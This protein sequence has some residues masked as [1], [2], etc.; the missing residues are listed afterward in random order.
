MEAGEPRLQAGRDEA[1]SAGEFE[2]LARLPLAEVLGRLGDVEPHAAWFSGSLTEGL[3]HA[4]SDVDIYVMVDEIPRGLVPTREDDGFC[5]KVDV[6]NSRRVDFEYWPTGRVTALADKLAGA[7]LSREDKN[8]LDLLPEYELEF[9]HR[10]HVGRPLL[11]LDNYERLKAAFDHR[12]LRQYLIE[13]K[14]MYIDDAFDDAV[15]LLQE[16]HLTTAVF[17]ARYVVEASADMLLYASGVTNSKE[18]HRIRLFMN[19]LLRRPEFGRVF[20]RFWELSTCIPPTD[21]GMALYVEDALRFS[22][23]IIDMIRGPKGDATDLQL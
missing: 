10:L 8:V 18:K 11:G 22:E 5:V 20:E 12:R 15:G 9:I 2:S 4:G 14:R 19:L 1:I 17:R 3:G 6:I 23:E 7:P 16:G 21:E 13:N